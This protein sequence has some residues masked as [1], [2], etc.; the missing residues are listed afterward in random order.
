LLE[1]RRSTVTPR[2]LRTAAA[3][4]ERG[5]VEGVVSV[6]TNDAWLTMPPEPYEYQGPPAIAGFLQGRA[7]VLGSHLRLVATRANR[8]P[9]FGCYLPDPQAA[10]AR[11]YG[12]MVLT[13]EHDRIAAI[14]WFGDC[15]L[16]SRF[17][18]PRTLRE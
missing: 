7:S 4:V 9:A 14:T 17:A 6:L 3:A 2:R 1:E 13:L 18:L 12:L 10:I 15:G 8:Q 11:F 5:D 16:F